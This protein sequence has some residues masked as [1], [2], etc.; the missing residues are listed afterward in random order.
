[1]PDH[2]IAK[3][4]NIGAKEKQGRTFCFLNG[5]AQPYEW[6]D[7]VPEDNVEFQGLLVV[8]RGVYIFCKIYSH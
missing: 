3:V 5:Q 1:M 6:M 8:T 7:E 4:N 2:I